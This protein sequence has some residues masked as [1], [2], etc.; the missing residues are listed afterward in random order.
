MRERQERALSH[1]PQMKM[2]FQNTLMHYPACTANSRIMQCRC[3]HPGGHQFLRCRQQLRHPSRCRVVDVN[4]TAQKSTLSIANRVHAAV[5]SAALALYLA[6][7]PAAPALA[8]HA[9]AAQADA[10]PQPQVS[11]QH[12][13][14]QSLSDLAGLFSSG[15]VDKD[16]TS[17][18]TMYG[19]NFK[20]YVIEKLN[21]EKIVSRKRG[22]TV[23]TCIS[24]IPQELET[25]EF[26][27]LPT[28]E[29]VRQPH[30]AAFGS[31]R[32]SGKS[33]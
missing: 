15:Q 21:G 31:K 3:R 10:G 33:W 24:V 19:T 32:L 28:S 17:P 11:M 7:G 30:A 23:D 16:P 20:K 2:S 26:Q 9:A 29:K 12:S 14:P 22:F 13:N 8:Q 25:P 1:L 4:S 6:L 5:P 18:F 27:G